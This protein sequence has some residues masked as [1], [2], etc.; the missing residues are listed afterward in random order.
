MRDRLV[1]IIFLILFS[2][3]SFAWQIKPEGKFHV[4]SARVGDE[5]LYSLSVTYPVNQDVL[6]PD[7]LYDFSP[8]ELNQKDYFFTR[9]DD[10]FSF[11]SAVYNLS[12]FE[13]DSI[14]VLSIPIWVIKGGD[15]TVYYPTPDSIIL[16]HVVTQIPDS[17]VLID[18]TI[19]KEVNYAFNYPYLIIG[20]IVTLIIL[21]LAWYFYGKDMLKQYRLYQLGRMHKKFIKTYNELI[22][23][24]KHD[25]EKSLLEWK[26]YMEALD[27]APY[28]KLTTKEIA[29]KTKDNLLLN[30]LKG[31]DRA[32]YG[33]GKKES[34][35]KYFEELVSF[36]RSAYASKVKKIKYGTDT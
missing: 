15:S 1:V 6:F 21:S 17:V 20:S 8:F 19:Y 29:R 5:I 34:D 22:H 25:W 33:K 31:I 4:D 16:N 28:T 24:Q 26:T 23:S 9:S 18:N 32:I 10:Q 14:Q 2:K 36:A 3:A 12:T 35:S 11:D 13:I 30:A 27:E 7:S